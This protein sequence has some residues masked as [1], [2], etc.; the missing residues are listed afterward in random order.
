MS[1]ER[2]DALLARWVEEVG[3]D[4]VPYLQHEGLLS[5]AGADTLIR[6]LP[7]RQC[8]ILVDLG[9]IPGPADADCLCRM[10]EM[11]VTQDPG[12]WPVLGLH[13]GNGHVV[14]ILDIALEELEEQTDFL[15]NLS[16]RV[17]AWLRAW[18]DQRER[19]PLLQEELLRSA[20]VGA[21]VGGVPA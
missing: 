1:Q 14:A 20:Q 19:P 17:P 6:Y 5:V 9:A 12:G 10:L 3:R 13:P 11:N 4:T 21:P 2:F 15:R 7:Q 8:R 16:R 18:Q